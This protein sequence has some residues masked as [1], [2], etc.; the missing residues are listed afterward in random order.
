M[1]TEG[2]GS[3]CC[4]HH[5]YHNFYHN[6]YPNFEPT[7]GPG[8]CGSGR[9]LPLVTRG[10]RQCRRREVRA[11]DPGR[12]LRETRFVP[13]LVGAGPVD[14]WCCGT[15]VSNLDTTPLGVT[16]TRQGS[17]FC[18]AEPQM[19]YLS[20]STGDPGRRG[21]LYA[22][23]AVAR[24]SRKEEYLEFRRMALQSGPAR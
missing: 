2:T 3:A 14:S 16:S 24:G 22:A 13:G 17:I 9:R 15:V 18:A 11:G 21:S 23:G 7:V 5:Y 20:L 10:R 1:A 12:G 8:V 19:V 4:Y 6:F